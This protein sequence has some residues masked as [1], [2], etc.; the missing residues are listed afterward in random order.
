[1]RYT[2]SSPSP[3]PLSLPLLLLPTHTQAF[4]GVTKAHLDSITHTC[5]VPVPHPVARVALLP[6]HLRPSSLAFRWVEQ[7]EGGRDEEEGTK[8]RLG[9][10]FIMKEEEA[11]TLRVQL[12]WCVPL[13]GED[14]EEGWD[15]LIDC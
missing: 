5:Q 12:F 15:G 8:R 2:D 10:S 14:R 3:H 1:M 4:A 6:F 11:E 13:G 7:G 9:M